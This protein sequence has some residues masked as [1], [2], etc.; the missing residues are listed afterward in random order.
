MTAA[1]DSRSYSLRR[2]LSLGLLAGLLVTGLLVAAGLYAYLDRLLTAAFD[3][4][5]VEQARV[6]AA[7]ADQEA[8]PAGLGPLQFEL[9]ERSR[10]EFL[11]GA[12]PA[13]RG[14]Y[15]LRDADGLVF[16]R[17]GSLRDVP[18]AAAPTAA[19]LP[20]PPPGEV[21]SSVR[22]AALPGGVEGRVVTLRFWPAVEGPDGADMDAE[23]A[24]ALPGGA[25]RAKVMTLV[26]GVSRRPLDRTLV[27][28]FLGLLGGG[29]VLAGAG[30]ATVA[31]TLRR[32]LRPLNAWATAVAK[33][34]PASAQTFIAATTPRE[35]R[36]VAD[37]LD[38]L[39][40]RVGDAL[41]RERRFTN[42]AAHELRT[43]LAELRAA[44]EV[45]LM[46]PSLDAGAEQTLRDVAASA[47]H[48]ARLLDALLALRRT[49]ARP[50]SAEAVDAAALVR[51]VADRHRR[52]GRAWQ[53]DV[54]PTL[55]L[56]TDAALLTTAVENLLNNAAAH[57]AGDGEVRVSLTAAA[58]GPLLLRVSNPAAALDDGVIEH[59]CEPFWRADAARGD[60][61]HFG[62]GLTL[63]QECCRRV[64]GAVAFAAAD[65]RLEARLRWPVS[66]R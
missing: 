56:Q 61:D 52:D 55:C 25:A 33:I 27:R 1:L 3:A 42:D 37:K 46:R 24:A 5:L 39:L 13:T 36:P 54:P 40:R 23:S 60:G 34:N 35:L 64:G 44:A 48:M 63:V 66:P 9:D 26:L 14:Y 20:A 50:T 2:R 32:A 31:L 65:G 38:D 47:S 62:L 19:A 28:V 59:A 53:V 43:P 45:A 12:D 15:D 29:L 11:T 4:A 6:L 51:R 41:A 58:E 30:V 21:R 16:A 49:D 18:A 57:A 17:S 10:P 22:D 7:M 8:T